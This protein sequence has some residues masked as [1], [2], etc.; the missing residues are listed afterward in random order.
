[1]DK[2]LKEHIDELIRLYD[3]ARTTDEQERELADFFSQPHDTLPEEWER[4]A[5]LFTAF[6]GSESLFSEAELEAMSAPRTSRR[7]WPW[8]MGAAATVALLVGFFLYHPQTTGAP[9][10]LAVAEQPTP[11]M[12]EMNLTSPDSAFQ[13][14][15]SKLEIVPNSAYLG[16]SKNV[17]R[18]GGDCPQT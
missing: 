10:Y 14:L 5:A 7:F 1:M 6:A 12:E 11:S 8:L 16:D 2:R 13:E 9:D 17:M 18:L 4:Y 15:V 3:E